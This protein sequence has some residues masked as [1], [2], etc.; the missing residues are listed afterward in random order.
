MKIAL[1][2]AAAK[3]S[4]WTLHLLR[5]RRDIQIAALITTFNSEANRVAMHTVWRS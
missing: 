4:A 2:G 3:D 1:S 5:Q